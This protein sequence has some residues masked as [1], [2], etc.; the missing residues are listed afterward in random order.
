MVNTSTPLQVGRAS[1]GFLIA[2]L[3]VVIV[4][5]WAPARSAADEGR[6]VPGRAA[7]AVRLVGPDPVVG[8][9]RLAGTDRYDQAV[10][11]AAAFGSADIV[12]LASGEKFADAL[13]ASAV[14]GVHGSPLLLTPAGSVPA[15]VL[16]QITRLRPQIVVVVGGPLSVSD[17][18]L[19]SISRQVSGVTVVRVDGADRYAVSRALAADPI[20]GVPRA[21]ELYLASG[22]DFPDA[23]TAS[24]AAVHRGMPVLLVDGSEPAPSAAETAVFGALGVGSV[25]I[26]GGPRSVG[27]A[28]EAELSRALAV[29]RISGADR[30]EVGVAVNRSVFS[31]AAT[32]YLASASS[33]PDALSGG[34]LA[35]LQ[36]APLYVVPQNCVP[37]SVLAELARLAPAR[38]VVL[39]GLATLGPGV[40]ALRPC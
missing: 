28:L 29:S 1:T 20:V 15:S 30:Y 9:V 19:E 34:P 37:A 31:S 5:G 3:L 7:D 6:S 14:A 11:A 4:G 40:D 39:G 12:Y 13:S 2:L 25:T 23:L 38:I 8:P 16:A 24:P 27:T 32:V 21:S 18:V 26:V 33:F 10:R 36:S 22:A 35:A 17:G